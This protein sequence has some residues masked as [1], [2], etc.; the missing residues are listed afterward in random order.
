MG[1]KS[2]YKSNLW[3]CCLAM[4]HFPIAVACSHS[5]SLYC[6]DC[7]KVWRAEYAGRL[8]S[9]SDGD[10][11]NIEDSVWKRRVIKLMGDNQISN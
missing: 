3:S 10:L 11:T 7:K 4:G 1:W 2:E 6:K 9:I 8:Q 5:I